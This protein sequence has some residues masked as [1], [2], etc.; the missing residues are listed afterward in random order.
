MK[1][2][3]TTGNI[4]RL[5]KKS[6]PVSNLTSL[7]KFHDPSNINLSFVLRRKEIIAEIFNLL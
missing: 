6:K 7:G 3:L 4:Y 1:N 5:K 2:T